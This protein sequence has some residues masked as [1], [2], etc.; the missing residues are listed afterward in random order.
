MTVRK[1]PEIEKTGVFGTG[2]RKIQL[3]ILKEVKRMIRAK[4]NYMCILGKNRKE[5]ANTP[6]YFLTRKAIKYGGI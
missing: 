5:Y 1:L 4:K 3:I 6:L 2:L